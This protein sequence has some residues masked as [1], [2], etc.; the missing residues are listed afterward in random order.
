MLLKLSVLYKFML[1]T[2]S[3]LSLFELAV[4]RNNGVQSRKSQ[5]ALQLAKC[6]TG[7]SLMVQS[8]GFGSAQSLHGMWQCQLLQIVPSSNLDGPTSGPL[9]L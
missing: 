5:L 6:W 9:G 3:A 8:Q 4:K 1:L 2:V 7:A